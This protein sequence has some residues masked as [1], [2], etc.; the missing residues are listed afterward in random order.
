MRRT[1]MA[2]CTLSVTA[3]FLMGAAK[4]AAAPPPT[5]PPAAPLFVLG[6]GAPNGEVDAAW[7]TPVAYAHAQNAQVTPLVKAKP[8]VCRRLNRIT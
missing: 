6:I 3:L 2:I 4:P 1:L 5:P 8:A 7:L